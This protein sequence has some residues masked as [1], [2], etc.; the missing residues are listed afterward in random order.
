MTSR[1]LV[2]RQRIEIE[3]DL[4]GRYRPIFEAAASVLE[5][6]AGQA[7]ASCTVKRLFPAARV[8]ATDISEYAVVSAGKWEQLC[9]VR[10]DRVYPALSYQ[11]SEADNSIDLSHRAQ[12]EPGATPLLLG[13]GPA[14][15]PATA[16]TMYRQLPVHQ[17]RIVKRRMTHGE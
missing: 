3:Q 2:E 10:L 6:G 15:L 8:V 7:W 5:L 4:V 16:A 17:T 9:Q 14:A 13:P 11:L 12:P 1:E